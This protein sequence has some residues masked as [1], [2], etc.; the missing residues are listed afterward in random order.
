MTLKPQVLPEP[1]PPPEKR[2]PFTECCLPGCPVCARES[3]PVPPAKFSRPPDI[4]EDEW[5]RYV[6]RV[7]I[8]AR[9]VRNLQDIPSH[10]LD[11][12]RAVLLGEV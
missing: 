8:M 7:V 5:W 10:A 4:T 6:S 11:H 3:L 2:N 1:P 12:M 9:S